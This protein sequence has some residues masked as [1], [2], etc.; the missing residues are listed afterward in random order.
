MTLSVLMSVY[1]NDSAAE[2]RE[3]LESLCSQTRPA[4]QVVLVRDGAIGD[5]LEF[6]ISDYLTKLPLLAVGYDENHGRAYALNYGMDFCT[7]DLIARMDADDICYPQRFEKQVC[8]FE[9]S[10]ELKILG[11]GIEEFYLTP[12]GEVIRNIR[13]Y[14]EYTTGKSKTLYKGTPLAHPTVMIRSDLLKLY[15]YN[16]NNQKYS[17]DIELWFRLLLN[18]QEIQTIQE[19]LL[20]F[21]ITDKTFSRRNVSKAKTELKIYVSSLYKLNGFSFL[22]AYPLIRFCS[23]LLPVSLI[24]RM[25]FSKSRQ[26][27]VK[28]PIKI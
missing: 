1:K 14:P 28:M 24:K 16:L 11:T 4:E 26:K 13:L 9:K 2:L 27:S 5:E 3:S 10:P 22:L 23:R 18:G 8:Q 19:P 21:R 6:V 17:Q 20:H 15:K 12:D 25:Y 7:C